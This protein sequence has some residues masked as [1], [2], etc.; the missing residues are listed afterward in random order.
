MF[1]I[2]VTVAMTWSLKA[3]S[4]IFLLFFA[5]L[6]YRRLGPNPKPESSCCWNE[7]RYIE[8]KAGDRL[9][10]GL[11]V[12][13]RLLLNSKETLDPVAKACAKPKFACPVFSCSRG[14]P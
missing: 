7:K 14:T 2:W 10:K 11:F 1:S 9:K 4:E 3:M 12:V 6:K 13:W 5:I 8:P